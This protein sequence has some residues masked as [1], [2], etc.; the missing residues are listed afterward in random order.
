MTFGQITRSK[1]HRLHPSGVK[2][3]SVCPAWHSGKFGFL[4]QGLLISLV[5]FLHYRRT[6]RNSKGFRDIFDYIVH[7]R[8]FIEDLL[9][10]CD[11]FFGFLSREH[12]KVYLENTK[13]WHPEFT[14]SPGKS[15]YI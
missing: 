6:A 5:H 9:D 4:S 8:K 2:M 3:G 10:L 14:V 1:D 15:F 12:P 11:Y 13:I 7:I